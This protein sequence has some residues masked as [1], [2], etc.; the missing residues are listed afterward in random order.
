MIA[1][2]DKPLQGPTAEVTNYLANG[3]S[4]L[5]ENLKGME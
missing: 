5:N 4:R 1:A 2:N 3:T